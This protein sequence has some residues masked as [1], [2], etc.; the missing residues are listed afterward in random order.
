ML[1]TPAV[2]PAAETPTTLANSEPSAVASAPESHP[3]PSETPASQPTHTPVARNLFPELDQSTTPEKLP[4]PQPRKTKQQAQEEVSKEALP[5]PKDAVSGGV[6]EAADDVAG[7]EA[8]WLSQELRCVANLRFAIWPCVQGF[9]RRTEQTQLKRAE[10]LQEGPEPPRKPGRPPARGRGRGGRGR[11]AS[12]G[13]KRAADDSG[14]PGQTEAECVEDWD[15]AARLWWEWKGYMPPWQSQWWED[16]Y[17]EWGDAPADW[18]EHGGEVSDAGAVPC[19]PKK[20]VRKTGRKTAKDAAMEA[21]EAAKPDDA[22][23]PEV[24]EKE[25]SF[26]RRPAPKKE[27]TYQRWRAIKMAFEDHIQ[28]F[29]EYPSKYQ[30]LFWGSY[31]HHAPPNH[32]YAIPTPP[33]HPI[34]HRSED[35]IAYVE[36]I[37]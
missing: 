18:G 3:P 37:I 19:R 5:E 29:V 35:K 9:S 1:E 24:E 2:E 15:E 4:D 7:F 10:P 22:D 13:K 33:P 11:G 30:E 20:K 25:P 34:I 12:K 23:A 36:S 27:A 21:C 17:D 16:W 8:G 32:L 28:L 26:A 31:T 6:S 14:Q